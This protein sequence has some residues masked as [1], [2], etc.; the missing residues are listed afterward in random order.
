MSW[1]VP[2]LIPDPLF[3]L[4]RGHALQDK[5]GGD[6]VKDLSGRESHERGC[7]KGHAGLCWTIE[8]SKNAHLKKDCFLEYN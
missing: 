8:F 6:G 7:R 2:W 1:L 4:R 3:F 5:V